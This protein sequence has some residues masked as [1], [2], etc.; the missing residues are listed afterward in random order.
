MDAVEI[1][2]QFSFE[3]AKYLSIPETKIGLGLFAGNMA[4]AIL[5][6]EKFKFIFLDTNVLLDYYGMSKAE[7]TKL[8]AF[9][10]HNSHR[11][12]LPYQVQI[13]FMRNR[14][15]A[16]EKDLFNPLSIIYSDFVATCNEIGNKYKSYL[17][18]KKIFYPMISQRYGVSL[19]KQVKILRN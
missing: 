18:K 16:I 10:K 19:L 8:L 5:L 3:T 7:K 14:L 9:F 2:S 17:E 15:G 4:D 13:E 6:D 1:N 11:I 12:F